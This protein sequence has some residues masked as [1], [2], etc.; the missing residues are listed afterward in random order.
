M[1]FHVIRGWGFSRWAPLLPIF[2]AVDSMTPTAH[3]DWP[4]I[5]FVTDRHNLRT[6]LSWANGSGG[7]FRVD[8]QLGGQKT[9]LLKIWAP[10]LIEAS[11]NPGSFHFNFEKEAT[12]PAYGCE[13]TSSHIEYFYM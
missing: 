13:N 11:S 7:K 12:R 6:L 2:I 10:Q 8:T 5:D 3:I 4:S 1:K 9:V